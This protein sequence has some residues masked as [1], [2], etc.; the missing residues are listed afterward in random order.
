MMIIR[1]EEKEHVS[2]IIRKKSL[3]AKQ[4]I[5]RSTVLFTIPRR[6][7]D[8]IGADDFFVSF[9]LIDPRWTVQKKVIKRREKGGVSRR[10]APIKTVRVDDGFRCSAC[11]KIE[12]IEPSIILFSTFYNFFFAS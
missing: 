6:L 7:F 2:Q 4:E 1:K 3:E 9:N 10:L 11:K 5:Y 8:G 12:N